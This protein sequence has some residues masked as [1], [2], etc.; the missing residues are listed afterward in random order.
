MSSAFESP[1]THET[2]RDIPS[3]YILTSKDRAFAYEYQGQTVQRAGLTVAKVME[4]G[5]S[6]FLSRPEEVKDIIISFIE[7]LQQGR[8]HL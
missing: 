5:H 6:P 7:G 3:T 1:I 4:T 8:S 2:Y